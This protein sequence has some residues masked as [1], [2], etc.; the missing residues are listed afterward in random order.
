MHGNGGPGVQIVHRTAI[1]PH[2]VHGTIYF[3]LTH[4][5]GFLSELQGLFSTRFCEMHKHCTGDC[6]AW[7]LELQ[8]KVKLDESIS[9]CK[10]IEGPLSVHLLLLRNLDFCQCWGSVLL[11]WKS[12]RIAFSFI[13]LTVLAAHRNYLVKPQYDNPQ[14]T[15]TPRSHAR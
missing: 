12:R 1:H 11:A 15:T 6:R 4:S 9:N 7:R 8:K 14:R 2:Y 10:C 3:L 13:F 5:A